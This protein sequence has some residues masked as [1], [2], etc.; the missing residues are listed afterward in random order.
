MSVLEG[1]AY[2][3]LQGFE[4]SQENYPKAMKMLKER[5]GNPQ[6]IIG[7]HMKALVSLEGHPNMKTSE[8]RALFDNINVH[9]RGLESLGISSDQYGCLLV[10]VILK[11]MP[12]DIN[13]QVARNVSKMYG[14]LRKL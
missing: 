5:F 6:T 3:A 4:I 2:M 8:L 7:T 1:P 13:L 10:P 9:I 11:R 14:T 12:E